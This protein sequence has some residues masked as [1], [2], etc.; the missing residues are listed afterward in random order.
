MKKRGWITIAILGGVFYLI[1]LGMCISQM[2]QFNKTTTR[3]IPEIKSI[4][5]RLYVSWQVT[6]TVVDSAMMIKF[7]SAIA[8]IN[9]WNKS[10]DEMIINGL[11]DLRQETNN[12]LDKQNGW[13]SF[14][15]AILALVGALLPFIIQL[16]VQ[17]DEKQRVEELYENLNKLKGEQEKIKLYAEISKLSFTLINCQNNKWSR[18]NINRN[19]FWND[20]L[21]SLC[22][23]TNKFVDS[24][25]A[26]NNLHD[27]YIFYLKMVLVQLHAVYSVYIPIYSQSYKSLQLLNLTRE[28]ANILGRLTNNSYTSIQALRRELEVMQ[29][30][31]SAF[32]L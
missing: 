10:R 32:S 25:L 13:F 28:I 17:H 5:V 4:P 19:S 30:H 22:K 16:K 1:L 31:M 20:M 2:S 9:D 14:W 11:D 7:D 26:C 23:Q 15:L 12:V 24:V 6:D 3:S 18:N 8:A 21:V 27:E 29:M